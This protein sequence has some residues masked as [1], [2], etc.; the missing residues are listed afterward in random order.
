MAFIGQS[1]PDIH[2]KLQCIEGLQDLTLRDLVKEAD[3][4]FHKRETEEEKEQRKEKE[5][6]SIR[7][8]KRNR[9]LTK[10]LATVV[11]NVGSN[12]GRG[13]GKGDSKGNNLGQ[14]RHSPLDPDQCAYCK[15]KGHWAKECS[16]KKNTQSKP[17]VLALEEED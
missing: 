12:R 1:A 17:A 5:R 8:K 4:V 2:R 15:D 9:D 3:K 7:D 13:N 11:E 6:E 16:Q 14:R 10:I